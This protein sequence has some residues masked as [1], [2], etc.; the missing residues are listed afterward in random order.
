ME[1]A[2]AA[3]AA[4]PEPEEPDAA[5]AAE[6]DAERGTRLYLSV[7]R[8]QLASF[9]TS[10]AEDL[11]ALTAEEAKERPCARTVMALQLRRSQK[12][13]LNREVAAT[14]QPKPRA[15]GL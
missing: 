7:I 5:A 8:R 3:G 10:A 13:I 9:S 14:V 4:P 12:A 15:K 2:A 11:D 6:D 1:D